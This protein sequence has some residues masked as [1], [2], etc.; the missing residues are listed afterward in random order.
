MIIQILF[1]GKTGLGRYGCNIFFLEYS[2]KVCWTL[3]IKTGVNAYPP[4]YVFQILWINESF[5]IL[6]T[7]S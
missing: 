2:N 4:K 1:K 6:F 7:A 5:D 3:S